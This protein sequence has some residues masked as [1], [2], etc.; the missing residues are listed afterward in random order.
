MLQCDEE[1]TQGRNMKLAFAR[2]QA[3]VDAAAVVPKEH[4]DTRRLEEPPDRV[5]EV[6]RREKR[7]HSSKKQNR[8]RS[9]GGDD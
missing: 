7:Q 9:F 4:V 1:R 2:L 6:R 5:K 3:L 8:T